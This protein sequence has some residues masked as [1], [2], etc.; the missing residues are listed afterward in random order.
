ME[1]ASPNNHVTWAELQP[2]ALVGAALDGVS[3]LS[4][5]LAGA[6]CH[7]RLQ[8]LAQAPSESGSIGNR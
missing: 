7:L 1:A 5:I 6:Q 2:H 4:D 8:K 3:G